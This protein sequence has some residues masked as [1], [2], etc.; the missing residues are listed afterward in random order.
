M[1]IL[2]VDDHDLF[3][4]GLKF[5]LPVL[6]DS[7]EFVEASDFDSALDVCGDL[8]ID[9]ILLDYHIPGVVGMN[10]LIHF[11]SRF[12]SARLVVVSGEEDP[13]VIHSAIENGASGYIPKSSSREELETALKLVLSGGTYL[14]PS[15]IDSTAL[16]SGGNGSEYLP[17][18]EELNSQLSPRQYQ[19]LMKAI[20]GKANKVIAKELSISDQTV[21]TH[22]S[23][24]FRILG[25][26][27]RT[28]AV[29]IAAK[30]GMRPI[31]HPLNPED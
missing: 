15:N 19:V 21:K 24:S 7:L 9:L 28:E 29:Y 5:L 23:H 2:L 20:Q 10:G 18:S 3:R 1:R 13:K 11:R 25:V 14:P 26:K 6:D 22:L 27:N 16:F 8:Q 31:E 4:E 30:L 12:E 17:A